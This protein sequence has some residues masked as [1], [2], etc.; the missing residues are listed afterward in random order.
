MAFPTTRWSLL[1]QATLH[2][3]ATQ[4]DAL[5]EFYRRYRQPVVTFIRWQTRDGADVEDLAQ[6]FFLQLIND[7]TLR[8][9]DPLRGRFRN[10]LLK[11]LTRFLARLRIRNEAAKR[12]SG[13]IPLSLDALAPGAGEP[14]VSAT[15]AQVFDRGWATDL[16]GRARAGVEAAWAVRGTT[17]EL[18][19]L[20]NFLPGAAATPTYETAATQLGW[21]LSRLKTEVFRL[22]TQFR[23]Q[24]RAEV[25][26]T[27]DTPHEVD[28]EMA[29]LHEVLADTGP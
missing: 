29:Y 10:F 16:L 15:E 26:L 27:V 22:R 11:A 23:E 25:A 6:E 14:A 20:R 8:R 3:G 13:E 1:A 19:T 2:G 18:D 12:G 5:A 24:V 21:T 7:S 9:A 17:A 4:A 28:A